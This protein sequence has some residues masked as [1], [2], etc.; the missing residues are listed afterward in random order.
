MA[1]MRG[2]RLTRYLRGL[3]LSGLVGIARPASPAPDPGG[4]PASPGDRVER[5]AA[6]RYV[7]ERNCLICHGRRGN[8][9]GELAATTIPKPRD[10]TRGLF[11]YRST[12]SG[13]LPTDADLARTIQSG[14]AGTAMP[15]FALLPDRDVLAVIAYIQSL[16][17]RWTNA[18]HRAA[19]VAL[20]PPPAWMFDEAAAGPHLRSGAELFQRACAACHGVEARGNGVAAAALVDDWEQPCPPRDLLAPALRIGP[21]LEALYRTLSTGLDGSPMPSFAEVT[22]T[23]ERWELVAYVRSLRGGALRPRRRPSRSPGSQ[24][25]GSGRAW[26]KGLE[27]PRSRGGLRQG[28]SRATLLPYH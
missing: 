25:R 20:P 22:T 3:L 6:G 21:S 12:P 2:R 9:K 24:P 27:R 26:R 5:I 23:E 16:S 17:P 18:V 14:L 13:S 19:P 8:G 28:C 1:G 11:K 4:E 10:F 7:F 15:A